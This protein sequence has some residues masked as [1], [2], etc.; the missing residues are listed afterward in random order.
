MAY[1]GWHNRE[2]WGVNLYLSE[3]GHDLRE[4]IGVDDDEDIDISTLR[5]FVEENMIGEEF[6]EKYAGSLVEDMAYC[7]LSEVNWREILNAH[8]FTRGEDE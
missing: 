4:I 8:G 3:Y 5:N 6:F 7:Y 2:T 1:N